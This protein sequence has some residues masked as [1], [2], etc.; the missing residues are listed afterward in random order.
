ML[1]TFAFLTGLLA[2]AGLMFLKFSP[3][4]GGVSDGESLTKIENS[5]NYRNG[6]FQN[7]EPTTVINKAEPMNFFRIF[8]RGNTIP[9]GDLPIKKL[10]PG[11]FNRKAGAPTRITW[12]SHSTV[13][14]EIDDKKILIDPM[15]GDK[16]SPISFLGPS[17]FKKQLPITAEELPLFDAVFI[18]HDHYDHLDYGSIRKIKDKVGMFYV[19]LGV[20]AHLVS[21]GID[22]SRITELDWW[23][24]SD[25][26]GVNLTLA[27][28]RHFSG[29]GLLDR[30]HTLW[31]SWIIKGN[32]S[33]IFFGGDS[34]YGQIF[35]KIG[36]AYG[37]FDLVMLDVGQYNDQWRDV[38]MVPEQAVQA[39]IDLKGAMLLPIHW[40][41]FKLS[42][43]DWDEP[44]I[45]LVKKATEMKVKVATP[46]MGEAVIPGESVPS[47]Q[48]WT[49]FHK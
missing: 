8:L 3:Q 19:P 38:H 26:A 12:L 10:E 36:E 40:G 28:S 16:S 34:G 11:Y 27:P 39:S 25:M 49:D 18:S 47:K 21:W 4:F 6:K 35:K 20:K 5:P 23:E 44:I 43:H 1:I 45:R 7:I 17:R 31:G 46:I 13:I 14:V 30:F 22:A 41:A 24:H 9:S 48:W 2:V 29:R 42:L 32:N 33:N 15:M 37:P